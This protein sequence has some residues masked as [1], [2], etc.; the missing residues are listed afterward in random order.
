M[1]NMNSQNGLSSQFEDF[2]KKYN[3]LNSESLISKN[4]HRMKN[5]GKVIVKFKDSKKTNKVM[6]N[7]K[8]LKSKG[9]QLRNLQFGPSFFINDS[10]CFENQ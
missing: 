5:K 7:L 8:E 10:M 3:K 4:C 2:I 9:E 6:F 1:V